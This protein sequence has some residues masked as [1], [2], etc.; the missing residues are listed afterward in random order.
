MVYLGLQSTY[1]YYILSLHQTFSSGQKACV[2]RK[3]VLDKYFVTV[4]LFNRFEIRITNT[5]ELL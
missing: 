4:Y 5:L 2:A 1:V 3:S